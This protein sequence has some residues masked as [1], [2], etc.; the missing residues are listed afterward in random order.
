MSLSQVCFLQISVPLGVSVSPTLTPPRSPVSLAGP[1]TLTQA[2]VGGAGWGGAAAGAVCSQRKIDSC[3]HG[4]ASAASETRG[5]RL[6][7]EEGGHLDPEGGGRGRLEERGG[8]DSAVPGERGCWA[9]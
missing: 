9:L 2:Q 7:G 3:C 8:G 1:P 4:D 5:I 6:G